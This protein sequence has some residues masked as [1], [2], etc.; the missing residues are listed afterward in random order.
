MACVNPREA[1]MAKEPNRNG[2]LGVMF[3]PARAD[4]SA[5]VD[6]RCGRCVDC[7][8]AKARD[9]SLRCLHEA[10]LHDRNCMVTWTFAKPVTDSREVVR[11][12]QLTMKR[13]RVDGHAFRYFSC[14]E[15]G[16]AGG[17][18]HGHS[19]LFGEDFLDGAT[20][21][22]FSGD[23]EAGYLSPTLEKAWARGHVMVLPCTPSSVFYVAGDMLKNADDPEARRI[24]SRRPGIGFGWLDRFS[25]DIRR[26]G[27]CTVEERKFPPPAAYL[28]RPEF[29][30]VFAALKEQRRAVMRDRTPL[31]IAEAKAGAE[32]RELNL[33]ARFKLGK[34]RA[35]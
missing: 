19:L 17:R 22:S 26:N 8:A 25:D 29:E 21:I 6:L 28:K 34:R 5:P 10:S 32:G 1:W 4:V 20:R 18:W 27:F 15:R 12:L 7:L 31:E 35:L 14:A 13:L 11:A 23:V 2:R 30:C 24:M 33:R 9:W 16:D 3:S